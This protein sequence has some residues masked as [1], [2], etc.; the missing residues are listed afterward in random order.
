MRTNTRRSLTGSLFLAFVTSV[1]VLINLTVSSALAIAFRLTPQTSHLVTL[2]MG[3]L[4]ASF[5]AATLIGMWHY[6]ILT[7]SFYYISSVWMGVLTYFYEAALLTCLSAIIIPAFPTE[8]W[9]YLALGVSVY[10]LIHARQI[11]LVTVP[12]TLKNLP[13]AWEGKTAVWISDVHLGQIYGAGY[14][15]RI[16]TLIEQLAPDCIFVGGDLFDGTGAPDIPELV[17]PLK[18]LQ[19]PYGTFFITGNHEEYGHREV[20]LAAMRSVGVRVVYDELIEVQGMQIIGVD[21]QNTSD[22]ARYRRLLAK[23]PLDRQRA[24]I[25]LKH[26]PKDIP[27]AEQAGIS[28]QISG[29][30]HKGQLWPLGGIASLVYHGFSYGLSRMNALQVYVSSGTGTWG[31]PLRVGTQSEIVL[32]TFSTPNA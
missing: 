12:I 17:A 28:L 31:P 11:L 26:E 22:T 20:F 24:S 30:T 18:R 7:R 10:G 23:L 15:E 14:A 8:M 4:S 21:Y 27:I 16:V 6:T 2:G 1:L 3:M 9:F 13:P 19:A 5:I 29:H 32:F 25:L